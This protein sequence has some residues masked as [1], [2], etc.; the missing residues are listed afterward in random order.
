MRWIK[1]WKLQENSDKINLYL[2]TANYLNIFST[3]HPV[4]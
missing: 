3:S 1:V 4:T 2:E